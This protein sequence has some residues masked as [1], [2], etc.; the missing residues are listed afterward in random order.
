LAALELRALI[1][2][3]AAKVVTVHSVAQPQQVAVAVDLVMVHLLA[4]QQLVV[5]VVVV[6]LLIQAQARQGQQE[7]KAVIHQ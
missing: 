4:M 3:L 6:G 2:L 7:I 5:L 1:K